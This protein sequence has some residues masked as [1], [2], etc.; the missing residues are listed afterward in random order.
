MKLQKF[1]LMPGGPAIKSKKINVGD[2]VLK[3]G[4]GRTGR[5]INVRGWRLDD[6]VEK[7]EAKMAL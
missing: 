7:L 3:V 5:M 4:Q 2:K 1:K 6:I